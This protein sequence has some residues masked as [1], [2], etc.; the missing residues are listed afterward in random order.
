[1]QPILVLAGMMA[2]L[3]CR[4]SGSASAGQDV[5]PDSTKSQEHAMQEKVVRSDDEWKKQLTPEQFDVTRCG[6]TEAPFTGKYWNNH[7]KGMYV[8]IGCG[9]ELFSSDTKYESGS[10]WPSFYASV[11]K[12]NIKVVK[13]YS[14]GMVRDEIRCARC[15][16]HLGHLFEDGP[17]PT[18]LRYCTNSASLNFIKAK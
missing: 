10:G 5:L 6:G 11:T 12:G 17:D 8:C 2:L 16:A 15:D 9:A 4:E 18:G 1:M 14:H 13:D 3:G 7:E